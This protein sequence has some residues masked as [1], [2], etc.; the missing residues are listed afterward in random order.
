MGLARWHRDG[1]R[2]WESPEILGTFWRGAP[3]GAMSIAILDMAIVRALE[4]HA[5]GHRYV[6]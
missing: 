6:Q 3:L 1:H 5:C 4:E 2:S